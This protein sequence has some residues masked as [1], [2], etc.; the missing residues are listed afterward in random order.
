MRHFTSVSLVKWTFHHPIRGMERKIPHIWR[1]NG[2]PASCLGSVNWGNICQS[3][4]HC[5]HIWLSPISN[6]YFLWV[7]AS[8][9]FHLWS[10]WAKPGYGREIITTPNNRK[11]LSSRKA[12]QYLLLFQLSFMGFS[13]RQDM[14]QDLRVERNQCWALGDRKLQVSKPLVT[15]AEAQQLPCHRVGAKGRKPGAGP[16]TGNAS[17]DLR[18]TLCWSLC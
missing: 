17:G 7:N 10:G 15:I 2:I 9:R 14:I 1:G 5:P 16:V 11:M 18:K 8:S 12:L 3:C 4:S 13:Q 6:L